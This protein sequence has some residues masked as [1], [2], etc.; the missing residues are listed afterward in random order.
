MLISKLMKAVFGSKQDR[1]AKKLRPIVDEVNEIFAGLEKLSDQELMDK[2]SEFRRLLGVS[3]RLS[4]VGEN[5]VL[6][7]RAED[8][9]KTHPDI[10]AGA[11]VGTRRDAH[12]GD[13]VAWVKP[14][15]GVKP[16]DD[17]ALQIRSG[18]GRLGP[19]YGPKAVFFVDDFPTTED[20]RG[21]TRINHHFLTLAAE[22]NKIA[23]W[24][25]VRWAD[26]ESK[27]QKESET[28][29]MEDI[30]PDAFA[31]MKEVC[32]RHVGKE[33][34]AAGAEIKWVAVPFDV[35]IMGAASLAKGNISEMGTGEGKTLTAILPIY[36]HALMGR[37][38]HLVTVN[39]YLARR[40]SEWNEPL[41]R[42][43]GLTVGCLDK[44]EP[45]TQERRAQYLAD[46]TYGTVN[47]FGFDYLRDNMVRH[48]SQLVQRDLYFA[49]IDEVDS[50]LI[51]EA[52]TPLIISGPVDRS[53]AQYDQIL[54]S[55][56][57]LVA[58]QAMLVSRFAKEAEDLLEKPDA[59][60]DTLWE[61]GY[62]MLQCFKGMPKHK[63]YMKVRQEPKFQRLQDKVE[64]QLM[65][66]KKMGGSSNRMR[67][68]EEGLFFLV[69]ERHRQIELTDKGRLELSPDN[70]DHFVLSD[71]VD[72]FSQIE[73]DSETTPEEKEAA[74][75]TARAAHEHKSG[76]LHTIS[77]LL[78]AFVL[79]IR[80][81]EYVVE[82]NKVVIV[83]EN[84]GRKMPGRRWSDGL[85][86]AVEAKE[87]VKIE[88]ETQTLATITIQNYFRQYASLSGMTGT[89]E[90]E[91]AEFHSTYK[92]DVICIPAN[93]PTQRKDLND[94]V[95]KSKREKYN[96]V[97]E[98]VERLH[99]LGLPVLVG[100]TNVMDSEK[101]S[102]IFSQKKLKHNVLNA[103]NNQAEA[104]IVS[105]AGQP[106]GITIAT[107]MAGRGTDIK[108]GPG[109]DETRKDGDGNEHIGGL[110]II[111]T[112]RHESRRI[113]RQLRGRSGRQ[114]DPGLSRFFVSLEDDLMRW[115]GSDRISVWLERMGMQEG[116]AIENVLVTRSIENAQKKVELINQERR[117]R[118]LKYDDVLNGQ[119]GVIYGLRRDLLTEEDVRP[120]MM[121]VFEDAIDAEFRLVYG[122]KTNMG[123]ADV[124][125]W[126]DW[127]HTTTLTE[128]LDDLKE[129]SW[130]EYE[131]LHDAVM[132]RVAQAFDLKYQDLA[133]T[134]DPFSRWIGLQTIDGMWQD[135]LLAIDDLRE[136]ITLRSYAQKD[137]LVE[138]TKDATSMFD[139]FMLQVNKNVFTTFFRAQP[140]S[141]EE[142]RRRERIQKTIEQ[143]AVASIA[144]AAEAQAQ[145]QAQAQA[146]EENA[147]KRP[148]SGLEPYR[149]DYPKVGR[150]EA[151]P[152]GSGKK[153][154]DCHGG[155]DLRE[156]VQHT[157][158]D[159]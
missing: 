25:E 128:S 116:E 68:L 103:K 104:A 35:Q 32:R 150:N 74:K 76:E 42:F 85:H 62:K 33:W 36:L 136:G 147:D 88:A 130:P 67:E 6:H 114:G 156:R 55:I 46:V 28:Y 11:F 112:E 9:L 59:D 143:K 53:T 41:F 115:F 79:K 145:A 135:H 51:D 70:P 64:L 49:I 153:Y 80:D 119:R 82:D 126:L 99:K 61:G 50:V 65:G 106:S 142:A 109:V 118:T 96:A 111:G 31:V 138:F 39:D 58:K 17:L 14:R 134:A 27:L 22:Q 97:T 131:A 19:G 100:T 47:E 120:V 89:A 154:K 87:A 90:T 159:E 105:E 12:P 48:K 37:G 21:R 3:P 152:C 63:R 158:N 84:T 137:P 124:A 113:D 93:R 91:A 16:S 71:I 23:D 40:D 132:E 146:A 57:D 144:A 69:D 44:T 94:L 157:I 110:Y 26:V 129:R 125:G 10:Q 123:D 24:Q 43:L 78:H 108:L 98:E 101:L 140:V 30:L 2:T 66:E 54:P 73:S 5:V 148:K 102:K 15:E 86:Q 52:R 1:D 127:V 92:M 4:R 121:G 81:I 95:F 8:V 141:E 34:L 107:N 75:R 13:V 72:E 139:E 60:A 133:D 29:A 20:A 117:Q 151:C 77:Q 83:D 122:E 7:E 38:A 18:M 56:R 155:A 45:H 149:R